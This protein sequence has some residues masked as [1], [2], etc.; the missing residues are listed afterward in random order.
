[1]TIKC[2]I[3]EF[4]GELASS[5]T[6]ETSQGTNT[7]SHRKR[8]REEEGVTGVGVRCWTPL[9]APGVNGK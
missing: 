4:N 9:E 5:L 2:I 3:Q 1:M 6:S 7:H 8:E